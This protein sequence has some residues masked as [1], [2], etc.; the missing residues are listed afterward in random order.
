MGSDAGV[1]LN[2]ANSNDIPLILPSVSTVPQN[3]YT[4][5]TLL[6][7]EGR[8]LQVELRPGVVIISKYRDNDDTRYE[9]N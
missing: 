4:V 5:V 7:S 6:F 9:C 1:Y 3:L 2:A 8:E